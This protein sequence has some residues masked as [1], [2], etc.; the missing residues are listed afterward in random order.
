MS[1]IEISIVSRD[2]NGKNILW[3]LFSNSSRQGGISV[4]NG[5][6]DEKSMTN[7]FDDGISISICECNKCFQLHL[8]KELKCD[9]KLALKPN[10][11]TYGT[12]DLDCQNGA[13]AR[14]RTWS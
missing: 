2:N 6:I 1:I 9:F 11:S 5:I 7:F 12:M 14:G 10:V 8:Y 13:A 3:M 4:S